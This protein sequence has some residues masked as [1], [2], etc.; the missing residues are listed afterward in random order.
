[1]LFNYQKLHLFK[2]VLNITR[3]EID[4]NVPDA[5]STGVLTLLYRKQMSY[6]I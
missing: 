5:K 3:V 6:I 4:A 2:Q 1:M